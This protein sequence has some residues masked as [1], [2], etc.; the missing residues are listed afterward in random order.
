[1]NNKYFYLGNNRYNYD[2]VHL[3]E[4]YSKVVHRKDLVLEIGSSDT[5]KTQDLAT[6]CHRLIGLEKDVNRIPKNSKTA[7]SKIKIINGDWYDLDKIFQ[8]Q[9]FDLVVAS[10]VIEHVQDDLSCINQTFDR[11]KNGGYFIF[12]TP[13]RDR[14]FERLGSVFLGKRIY[15]YHEHQREYTETDIVKLLNK[16]KFR[17]CNIKINGIVLGIHAGPF[18]LFFKRAPEILRNWITF[19]EVTIQK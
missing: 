5:R 18:Y 2:W 4:Q 9:Q 13:N 11:L 14:L 3:L 8:K 16:S 12:T 15:P 10:H 7:V 17:C 6:F 1:M 19:W